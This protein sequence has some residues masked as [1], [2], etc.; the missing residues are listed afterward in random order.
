MDKR[1]GLILLASI[2]LPSTILANANVFAQVTLTQ[3]DN[4]AKQVII[5]NASDAVD[6]KWDRYDLLIGSVKGDNSTFVIY[7]ATG[8]HTIPPVVCGPGTHLEHG[9]CVP[10]VVECP[11]GQFFNQ[12][13]EECQD[14]PKPPV[15]NETKG[16]FTKINFAGDFIGTG[17]INAMA[18]K[19]ADNNVANGDLGYKS[20]IDEFIANFNKLPGHKCTPGNHEQLEDGSAS[21][22]KASSQYCGDIWMDKV[23]GGTT[24]LVGYNTNGNLDTLLGTAQDA[25]MDAQTMDGVKNVVLISHKPCQVHPN[26]HHGVES[27]VKTFCQSFDAKVPAG[28]AIYHIDAHNHELAK[29]SDGHNFLVGGGGQTSHRGCGTGSGWDFCKEQ[30]GF[31]QLEINNDTGE[32]K[33]KF[34]NTSGGVIS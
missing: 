13:S 27:A 1:T 16:N 26:A 28:V 34:Y 9:K 19:I 11:Q 22:A 3:K 6:H 12:T 7:N 14:N 23:A 2:L 33:A 24:L 29:T 4:E 8:N 17:T 32:I 30:S 20:T 25:L 5:G 18:K 21:L 10:N 15:D 31:L